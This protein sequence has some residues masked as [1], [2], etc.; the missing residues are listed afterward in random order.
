MKKGLT[1]SKGEQNCFLNVCIQ[2][3]INIK[4]V[5]EHLEHLIKQKANIMDPVTLKLLVIFHVNLNRK[6][7]KSMIQMIRTFQF[8][9]DILEEKYSK[10]HFISISSS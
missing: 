8:H 5:K 2:A 6:L 4:C 1:N 9:P 10:N 3:L 7:F